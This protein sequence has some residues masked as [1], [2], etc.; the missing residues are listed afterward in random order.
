MASDDD[1]P[2]VADHL[3]R[4]AAAPADASELADDPVPAPVN[5]S[6]TREL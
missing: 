3:G 5:D 2:T 6:V 1:D 4:P